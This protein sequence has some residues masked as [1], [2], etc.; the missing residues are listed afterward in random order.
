MSLIDKNRIFF[1]LIH[2]I[3]SEQ[4]NVNWI[5]K[6]SLID[7]TGISSLLEEKP[8]KTDSILNDVIDYVVSVKPYHVQFS[9]YFEHYQTQSEDVIIPGNDWIE[10]TYE[11]CFDNVAPEPNIKDILIFRKDMTDEEIAEQIN[12]LTDGNY[13]FY[14]EHD[15]MED[16]TGIYTVE[17]KEGIDE[18]TGEPTVVV[19]YTKMDEREFIN[20]SFANKV[21]IV[22]MKRYLKSTETRKGIYESKEKIFDEIKKDINANFKGIEIN[23]SVF[24]IANFGYDIFDYDTEDYDSPTIIY[25]YFIIDLNVPELD[26]SNPTFYIAEGEKVYND[27]TYTTCDVQRFSITRELQPTSSDEINEVYIVSPSGVITLYKNAEFGYDNLTGNYVDIF[28]NIN[29]NEKVIA[30]NRQKSLTDEGQAIVN[31]ANVFVGVAF[32]ES[33]SQTLKRQFITYNPDASMAML[34][35]SSD[36]GSMDKISVQ[37]RELNGSREALNPTDYEIDNEYIYVH[38]DAVQPGEHI[39]MTSFDY[40]Y[41]Y[42]KIY[43]WED[44]YGLSNNIVNLYGDKF[45]R[46]RYEADRPSEL[47][48]SSPDSA[49]TFYKTEGTNY[50]VLMSDWK[51]DM[52]YTNNLLTALT[53]VESV[54][55]EPDSLDRIVSITFTNTNNF[56]A[57]DTFPKGKVLINGEIIA[58][59]NIDKSTRTISG[60]TRGVDGTPENS[61][62]L[63][64]YMPDKRTTIMPGDK[65][66]PY[67]TT[68]W[69][70]HKRNNVCKSYL[71]EYLNQN[72]FI[73]PTGYKI[74]SKIFMTKNQKINLLSDVYLTSTVIT[75]DSPN[76]VDA[77]TQE[78]IFSSPSYVTG[79]W[80]LK[81]D[82]DYIPFTKIRFNSNT[83]NY[84]L[85]GIVFPEKYIGKLEALYKAGEAK[86]Y[87]CIPEDISPD[88]FTI[89]IIEG[90]GELHLVPDSQTKDVYA[91]TDKGD[92]IFRIPGCTIN[93]EGEITKFG[94]TIYQ[95]STVYNKET[96]TWMNNVE[97]NFGIIKKN[98]V[99][100]TDGSLYAKLID[101]KFVLVMVQVTINTNEVKLL[102]GESLNI[103]VVDK[104]ATDNDKD[105]LGNYQYANLLI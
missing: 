46:A 49:V 63:P 56:E 38:S 79:N 43:T 66:L 104:E 17:L 55:L 81:I 6:T 33:N 44:R 15:P 80:T 16:K 53:E 64:R 91:T 8:Y 94:T 4:K 28:R 30:V 12:A 101:D 70:E 20:E 82:E 34:I 26:T 24:D 57:K 47:C 71:I 48:V 9:H 22:M 14:Y 98:N 36:M 93:N 90:D 13:Y 31:Y 37:K 51:N 67:R 85:S 29:L 103:T 97:T 96:E 39:V 2:Y 1:A 23:G 35:P 86:I 92:K 76:V 50:D 10:P 78:D 41:L 40:K 21:F 5:L 89:Q 7:F 18:T 100:R 54:E 74:G 32:K 77:Q 87:S 88:N 25:D 52:T 68:D 65:A 99:Y 84:D 58:Y 3:L 95:Y 27:P 59:D 102:K 61:G 105:R 62:F 83:G 72:K 75:L 60:L 42:D 19:S 73:C 69:A 11:M 45:L